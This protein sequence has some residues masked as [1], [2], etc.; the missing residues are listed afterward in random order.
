MVRTA[1]PNAPPTPAPSVSS[2]RNT[3]SATC[4]PT[5][6]VWINSGRDVAAGNDCTRRTTLLLPAKLTV[7]SIAHAGDDV[8]A[9]VEVGINR[10]EVNLD[11][12]VCFGKFA[13]AIRRGEQTK[14]FDLLGTPLF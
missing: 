8:A 7:A 4:K 13:D 2:T 14:V 10:A 3:S 11:V 9:V 1:S 5:R 12:V 6:S